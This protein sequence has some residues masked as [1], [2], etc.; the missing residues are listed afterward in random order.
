MN[1]NDKLL[2]MVDL[3]QLSTVLSI[4][5]FDNYGFD[6]KQFD[7]RAITVLTDMPADAI[8]QLERLAGAANQLVVGDVI[9]DEAQK[10]LAGNECYDHDDTVSY[11][12][13]SGEY[14]VRNAIAAV[15]QW[16]KLNDFLNEVFAA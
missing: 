13:A 1:I 8:K 14:S 11:V 9:P 16:H 12:L 10:A 2:L 4:M 5:A 3:P 15:G 7:K 6:G